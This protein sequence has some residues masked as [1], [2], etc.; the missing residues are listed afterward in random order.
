MPCGAWLDRT[1]PRATVDGGRRCWPSTAYGVS[2]FPRSIVRLHA[3]PGLDPRCSTSR[4]CPG[5]LKARPDR[6]HAGRAHAGARHPSTATTSRSPSRSASSWPSRSGLNIVVGL[7]GLLDLGYVAFFAVG[8]YSW[9]IFGSPQAN[10]IFGGSAFPLPPCVVLRLPLRRRRR[11]GGRGH[12]ARPARPAPARRLPRHR[13]A[14]VRRGDPRPRQQP[15]QA[16]QLHQRA[17][18]HHAHLAAAHLLRARCCSALG[19]D[20]EPQR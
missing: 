8:A 4:A 10:Q 5:R 18:G 12:P 2:H 7:A 11:G 13:D 6:G 1:A 17:Q 14:G 15:R 20:A 16:D 19:I 9:A 3:L